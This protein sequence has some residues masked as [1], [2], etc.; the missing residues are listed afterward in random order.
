[1]AI[2]M[3]SLKNKEI[4]L[5]AHNLRRRFRKRGFEG[6]HDR[7]LKDE[8]LRA[9]QLEHDRTEEVCIKMD[10]LADK[11]FTH[12]MTQAEYFRYKKNLWVSL[13][14]SGNTGP[15]RNRSDFNDALST[16]NH[17]HQESRERQF[18]PMPFWKYQQWHQS[19]SSS[20]S[21]WQ[22]SDSWWSS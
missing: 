14:K 18:R 16:L 19:S 9:S 11:D 6:I 15:L 12:H 10:E 3:G 13:N 22:W 8:I 1:M 4:M 20:S 5:I 21:W 17:L 7:F 2:A